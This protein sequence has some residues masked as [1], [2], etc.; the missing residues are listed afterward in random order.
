MLPTVK[1]QG[2]CGS[3]W[4]FGS[5]AN[6][7]AVWYIS[8]G[9]LV[10]LSEQELVSCAHSVDNSSYPKG[11][12]G[13]SGA[14]HSYAWVISNGG[15]ASTAEYGPYISGKD[16]KDHACDKSKLPSIA[17]GPFTNFTVLPKDEAQM[18]AWVATK[19]PLSVHVNAGGWSAYKG[20]VMTQ[21]H[22]TK[23]NHVVLVVGYGVDAE[24]G[25]YWTIRNSWSD[26]WGEAGY[27]RLARGVRASGVSE[28]PASILV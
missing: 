18:K 12:S 22:S 19:G 20:G 3:C 14:T 26:G 16:G 28:E 9:K 24:Q 27:V 4:S 25:D 15:L 10:D 13:G 21:P 6:M 17:A 11:C 23:L 8:K 7:E 2:S 1:D 5:S